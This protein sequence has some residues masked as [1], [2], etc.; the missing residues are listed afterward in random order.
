M[1]RVGS[2]SQPAQP[3]AQDP[4]GSASPA[5]GEPPRNHRP[6][7][8]PSPH[9]KPRPFGVPRPRPLYAGPSLIGPASAESRL[10]PCD[11]DSRMCSRRRAH[12]FRFSLSWWRPVRL[13][14]PFPVSVGRG[15]AEGHLSPFKPSLSWRPPAS[16]SG[17]SLSWRRPE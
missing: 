3:P 15:W 7:P 4:A 8:L 2:L 5:G 10:R 9:G 13:V 16:P 12:L 6:P 1:S 17:H 11:P 14:S